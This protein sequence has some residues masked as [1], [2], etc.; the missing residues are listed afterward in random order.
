[1]RILA[2]IVAILIL[3]ACSETEPRSATAMPQPPVVVR[4]APVVVPAPPTPPLPA[5]RTDVLAVRFKE[6]N[7]K[8]YPVVIITNL[9]DRDI[10]DIRGGFRLADA[11]GDILHATGLTSA[12]PGELFLAA[13]AETETVPF[14]L[15]S[16][17]EPMRRLRAEP[18]TLSFTFEAIDV[19]FMDGVQE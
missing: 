10:D 3:T 17:D 14:G 5:P 11:S 1:M 4:D 18:D 13:G 19:T 8:G 9:T 15:S 12:I 6:I 7:E 16:K 2:M